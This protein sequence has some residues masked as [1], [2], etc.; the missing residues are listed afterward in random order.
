MHLVLLH[1]Q[2][3]SEITKKVKSDHENEARRSQRMEI[4][5]DLYIIISRPI[6]IR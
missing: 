1:N 3:N 2:I 6:P 4:P 5:L